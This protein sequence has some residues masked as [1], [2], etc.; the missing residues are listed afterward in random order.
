MERM[1]LEDLFYNINVLIK[2][3][4]NCSASGTVFYYIVSILEVFRL[5]EEYQNKLIYMKN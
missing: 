5:F 3:S 4:L 2:Y 1:R